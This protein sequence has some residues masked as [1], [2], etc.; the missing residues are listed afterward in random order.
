MDSTPSVF[1]WAIESIQTKD[2]IHLGLFL[3]VSNTA[4]LGFLLG[5]SESGYHKL[6]CTCGLRKENT[7]NSKFTNK[8]NLFEVFLAPIPGVNF[9]KSCFDGKH[10]VAFVQI[11]EIDKA[12]KN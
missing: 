3:P 10:K 6:L 7:N 2:V 11:G 1:C 12:K 4:S 5:M 9:T 8:P